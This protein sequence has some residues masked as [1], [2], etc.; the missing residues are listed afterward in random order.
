M[1]K[2]NKTLIIGFI[3][4]TFLFGPFSATWAGRKDMA[5]EFQGQIFSASLQGVPLRVILE[6]L[7]RGKGIWFSGADS[8]FDEEVTVQFTALTLEDGI[9]R[10]LGPKNYG[11]VL[12]RME[13]SIS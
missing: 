7:E 13:E 12:D 9:K 8:L 2:L 1:V 10:I 6:R 4:F 3:A 5:L 11:L